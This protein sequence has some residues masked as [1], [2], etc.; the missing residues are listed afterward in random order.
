MPNVCVGHTYPPEA[1]NHSP[2]IY[3]FNFIFND[4]CFNTVVFRDRRGN[5]SVK[6]FL[7]QPQTCHFTTETGEI[8]SSKITS[9]D[10]A[11]MPAV[12]M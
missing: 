5:A 4:D 9:E 12:I 6:K 2:N 7:N 10:H 1:D 11:K 8:S 3:S